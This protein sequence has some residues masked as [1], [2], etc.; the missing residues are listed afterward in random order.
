MLH[1]SEAP[2]IAAASARQG[3]IVVTFDPS[4]PAG[5]LYIVEQQQS[6][7]TWKAMASSSRSPITFTVHNPSPGVYWVR[8]RTQISN[9]LTLIS[10]PR[11]YVV[12]KYGP[13]P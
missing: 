6:N 12:R 13:F 8:V 9:A 2:A 7:K 10:A 4:K 3:R 5:S 11:S 1:A